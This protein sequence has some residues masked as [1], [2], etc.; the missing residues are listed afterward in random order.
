MD[1]I[2]RL[3]EEILILRCQAGDSSA[4]NQVILRFHHPLRYFVRRLIGEGSAADDI[5]QEI[6]LTVYRNMGRL[7]RPEAFSVWLYQIARN[8]AYQYLRK[9]KKQ[10]LTHYEENMPL[11]AEETPDDFPAE[12][13]ARIHL[14]LDRLSIEQR[15]VLV[16]R[17][18]EEMSYQEI[19]EVVGC[20]LGT[21]RSR[22][23]YAKITLRKFMEDLSH[24]K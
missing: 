7:K 24:G 18:L 19:S 1:P 16:L 5:V 23:Y 20:S 3:S 4:F 10:S 9:E 11:V 13:A 12:D 22:I 2:T 21:V 14:G 17:F 6:W 8:Q 15:E